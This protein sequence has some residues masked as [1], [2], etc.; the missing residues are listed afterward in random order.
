MSQE[1]ERRIYNTH[2]H[3][4]QVIHNP[5]NPNHRIWIKNS[6][7]LEEDIG[8]AQFFYHWVIS[9]LGLPPSPQH[10]ILRKDQNQGYLLSNLEWG[11]HKTQ[12]RRLLRG[13]HVLFRGKRQCLKAWSEELDISYNVL[14]GRWSRGTFD[15]AEIVKDYS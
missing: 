8:T 14:Y 3:I 7:P 1:L 4:R 13:H 9:Q 10:R 5:N 11:T 12:G 15:L 2:R 6:I